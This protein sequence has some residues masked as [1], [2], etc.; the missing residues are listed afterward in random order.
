MNREQNFY[1]GTEEVAATVA[2]V[3][4]FLS[5]GYRIEIVDGEYEVY[6]STPIGE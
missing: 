3:L 1:C 2:Q 6:V 4:T 5:V